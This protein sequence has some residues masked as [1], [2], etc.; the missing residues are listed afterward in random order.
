MSFESYSEVHIIY[1][2]RA[3]YLVTVHLGVAVSHG[4]KPPPPSLHPP[5]TRTAR[6]PPPRPQTSRRRSHVANS[7]TAR[8]H[9]SKGSYTIATNVYN[10]I[11]A[12][13]NLLLQDRMSVGRSILPG[14][15]VRSPGS[16]LPFSASKLPSIDRAEWEQQQRTI[17]IRLLQL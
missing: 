1:Q 6:V 11:F 15:E 17:D 10:I 4:L 8:L 5:L 12:I 16:L 14:Q 7:L 2:R 9:S 13:E 3:L